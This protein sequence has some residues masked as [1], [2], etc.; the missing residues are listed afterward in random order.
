MT[1]PCCASAETTVCQQSTQ[2]D[3]RTATRRASAPFLHSRR[4]MAAEVVGGGGGHANANQLHQC[5]RWTPGSSLP[6]SPRSYQCS[7]CAP[8]TCTRT[9]GHA[10]NGSN[11]PSGAGAH[12]QG[13]H[14]ARVEQ[15]EGP[16]YVDHPGPWGRGH[17]VCKL[18]DA[19]A[20]G[21]EPAPQQLAP[22][23]AAQH[24]SGSIWGLGLRALLRVRAGLSTDPSGRIRAVL[25]LSGA[26]SCSWTLPVQAGIWLRKD[27]T[28]LAG[29]TC[30]QAGLEIGPCTGPP[31]KARPLAYLC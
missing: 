20:G 18:H 14:M 12:L 6:L 10:S 8:S 30:L 15:V 25:R 24:G 17:A 21:H 2:T 26:T 27:G 5:K 29:G 16:V 23:T 22:Q 3:L 13:Q 7:R 11:K 19:P 4:A 1:A 9:H 28:R 31:P